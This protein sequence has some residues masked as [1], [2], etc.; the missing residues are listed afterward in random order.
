MSNKFIVT[1]EWLEEMEVYDYG[2]ELQAF[3]VY[4]PNGGEALE[5]LKLCEKSGYIVFGR[6]LV[7]KLPSNY[8]PPLILNNFMGNLLYPNDVY[9]KGD[10]CVQKFIYIKGSLKAEG[11]ITINKHGEIYS[12]KEYV[13]ADEIDIDAD[14]C[15]CGNVKANR[16]NLDDNARIIG[17]DIVTKIFNSKGGQVWDN[18]EAEEV[19]N[20]G[21]IIYGNVNA[22]KI[23]NINGGKIKGKT[24]YKNINEQI[25]QN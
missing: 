18:I 2:D 10:M 8:Y 16:I 13:S 21:G 6:W 25:E 3:N 7:N 20:N 4:F 17:K 22:V 14:G 5:V 11:K 9:V 15:I 24:I 23:E 1:N 19:I 12:D